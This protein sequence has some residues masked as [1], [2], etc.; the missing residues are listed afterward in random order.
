MYYLE[1]TSENKSAWDE[2]VRVNGGTVFS[3]TRYLDATADHWLILYN[4]D[5]TGGMA[6]PYALKAGQLVLYA[7]FFHRYTEWLGASVPEKDLLHTLKSKFPVADA[8]LRGVFD[9]VEKRHH[10]VLYPGQVHYNQQVKRSLKKA[11][12]FSVSS[13]LRIDALKV[14]VEKELTQRIE[15]INDTSLPKL[16]CLLDE[17]RDYGLKQL[18]VYDGA[19]WK[20]GLWLLET[21]D[22]VLYLK[23]TVDPSVRKEGAMYALMHHAICYAHEQ[24][25]IMDFGGSNVENVR[26]FNLHFGAQDVVYSRLHWNHAPFWWR[27]LKKVKDKWNAKS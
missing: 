13:G 7:P 11:S 10:Q 15:S 3:Q 26:R 21:E 9:S 27:T 18:N 19:V 16:W 12:G 4:E 24:E 1:P 20:G 6:C 5:K 8:Q 25:K 2:F 23:G 22:T 14:L 17:Y